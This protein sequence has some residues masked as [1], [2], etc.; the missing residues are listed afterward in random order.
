MTTPMVPARDVILRDGSTLRLD[1]PGNDD[2]PALLAFFAALSPESAFQRFHGFPS[3]GPE[4]VDPFLSPDWR[5]RGSLIG[6]LGRGDET[7]IVALASY[8]RLRDPLSAE[9]AFA[10]ADELQGRGVGTRLLEQL[11]ALA[12]REGIE[13]FIA[14]VMAEQPRGCCACSRK[15]GFRL[16]RQIEGGE[17]EVRLD[18][19]PTG[20]YVAQVDERD[21]V[22]VSASLAPFFAPRT[23][24]V[25]GASSRRGS[26]GGELYR[27]ILEGGFGGPRIPSTS[28]ASRWLASARSASSP[29]SRT[30]STLP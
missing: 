30:R 5:E 8:V 21:H 19:E 18:I 13:Q 4:L 7:R 20:T 12:R 17:I 24:A 15:P 6:S 11:A 14:I 27:N 2:G 22:A 26:I 29:R 25:V 3:L 28:R 1:A 16:A 10:V 9:V 23:V